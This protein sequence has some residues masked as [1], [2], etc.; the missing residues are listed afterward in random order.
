MKYHLSRKCC[1][2]LVK[3][4]SSQTGKTLKQSPVFCPACCLLSFMWRKEPGTWSCPSRGY[5]VRA[6]RGCTF[7]NFLLHS[8]FSL[9]SFSCLCQGSVQPQ[10]VLAYGSLG[11]GDGAFPSSWHLPVS[12]CVLSQACRSVL[13]WREVRMRSDVSCHLCLSEK[14]Q[15]SLLLA[16]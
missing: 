5:A 4:Y 2:H 3:A 8:K 9:W 11:E 6:S 12:L 14:W 15:K 1:T 16:S 13:M 10:A 7:P